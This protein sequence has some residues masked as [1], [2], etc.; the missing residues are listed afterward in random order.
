[1][2]VMFLPKA[3]SEFSDK[4]TGKILVVEGDKNLHT[5]LAHHLKRAG[6]DPITVAASDEAREI[7]REQEITAVVLDLLLPT[8]DVG[9]QFLQEITGPNTPW[10]CPIVVYS[11]VKQPERVTRLGAAYL[12]KP[13]RP[14]ALVS[15]LT[16][17]IR[18]ASA[19]TWD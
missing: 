12:E 6:Y 14:S 11:N 4:G 18:T 7:L 2:F 9:W 15:T 10:H 13:A 8:I 5:V 16:A 17:S 1:K 3:D 19:E